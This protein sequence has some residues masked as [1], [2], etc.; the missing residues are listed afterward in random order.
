ML[1]CPRCAHQ[2]LSRHVRA[3]A[4]A[5]TRSSPKPRTPAPTHGDDAFGVRRKNF[6]APYEDN[7]QRVR[8]P[9]GLR[10]GFKLETRD[11]K[12]VVMQVDTYLAVDDVAKAHGLVEKVSGK[13]ETVVAWNA[14]IRHAMQK[15]QV[16][17]AL[18]FYNDVRL[19]LPG[20]GGGLGRE[21]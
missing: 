16:V 5:T 3:L 10:G 14:L 13:I 2:Q 17:R 18:K 1:K 15:G 20:G 4:T 21:G 8:I 7:F 6:G 9:Q 19:V 12:E 11:P